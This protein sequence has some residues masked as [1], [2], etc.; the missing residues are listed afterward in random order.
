[1]QGWRKEVLQVT[2]GYVPSKRGSK[3][4]R[5]ILDP[6]KRSSK[7]KREKGNP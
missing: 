3:P 7:Q 2:G 6:G 1:M 5:K 4:R